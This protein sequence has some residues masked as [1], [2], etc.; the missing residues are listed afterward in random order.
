[1]SNAYSKMG[2]RIGLILSMLANCG[3]AAAAE[4]P[5]ATVK[6]PIGTPVILSLLET[7]SSKTA[8]VGQKVRFVVT[9]D[10]VVEGKTVI[11]K[12]S[13]AFGEV[14]A[15]GAAGMAGTAGSLSISLQLVQGID[16]SMIPISATK[17]G[18]GESKLAESVAITALCC[19]FAIFMKGKDITFEADSTYNSFTLAPVEVR[20]E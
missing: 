3:L 8:Q 13:N 5:K 15:A 11:K 6:I 1:M 19:I 7:I 14:T 9:S 10:V 17:G 20:V 12:M 4:A 18:K 16:G 2:I